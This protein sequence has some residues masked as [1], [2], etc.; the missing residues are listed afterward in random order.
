MRTDTAKILEYKGYRVGQVPSPDVDCVVYTEGSET[1]IGYWTHADPLPDS[2]QVDA[3]ASEPG[4]APWLASHGGNPEAT[5]RQET[6]VFSATDGV[7]QRAIEAMAVVLQR[8][9]RAMKSGQPRP[10]KNISELKLE[11]AKVIRDRETE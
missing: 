4:Y 6:L 7:V 9:F 10:S 1:R 8:E 3:W 2:A 11:M 5:L